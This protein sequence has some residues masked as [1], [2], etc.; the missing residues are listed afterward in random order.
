MILAANLGFPR[1]GSHRELKTA[2]EKY[3]KGAGSAEELRA[4]AAA[5]RA[6]HWL[7]QQRAGL[8]AYPRQ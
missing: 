3:W 5:L 2:L 6:R 4:T 8:D 1:M 7:I